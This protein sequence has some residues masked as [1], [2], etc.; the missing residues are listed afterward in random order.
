MVPHTDVG[1]NWT[2]KRNRDRNG[3]R[4]LRSLLAINMNPG[5]IQMTRSHWPSW[6][7]DHVA[8]AQQLSG[9]CGLD[10]LCCW[11]T[12]WEKEK[13]LCP[14]HSASPRRARASLGA[15]MPWPKTFVASAM[16]AQCHG[17]CPVPWGR[18][19]GG[20]A[21]PGRPCAPPAL[22]LCGTS[23]GRELAMVPGVLPSPRPAL[24][25]AQLRHAR[26]V[27]RL[28]LGAGIG[29]VAGKDLSTGTSPRHRCWP[30]LPR[31]V[32]QALVLDGG[33]F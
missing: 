11:K 20:R 2:G 7:P 4:N 33:P 30:C 3:L 10:C 12:F 5:P 27:R 24:D 18:W 1:F 15:E 17:P 8:S 26:A 29:Q 13:T 9:S 16:A 32:T 19:E 6:Y 31:T 25:P 14:G 28:L 21:Q 23:P 22:T